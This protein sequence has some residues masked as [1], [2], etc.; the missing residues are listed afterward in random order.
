MNRSKKYMMVAALATLSCGA[1]AQGLNT[2]YFIDG[3]TFR[4]NLNPAYGNDQNYV[5]IPALG[6]IQVRTQGNFGLGDVLFDNPRYGIDSDKKKTTFMNPYIA[7]GEALK[8]FASGNNRINADV[9]IT[10]LSAGFKAWGGYNTISLDA[11]TN[12][13]L[14]LPYELFAFA[15]NTGNQSYD[16]GDIHA[17]AQSFVQLALGHSRQIDDR[18]RVGA[19][20]KLLFGVARADAEIKD[21][22]AD[23]SGPDKWTMT[24]QAMAN[25]SMKGFTYKEEQKEYKVDGQGTYRRVND[26]DVDGAGLGGFGMA[27]DFGATYKMDGERRAARP[28]LHRMEQ[29]HAGRQSPDEFRVQRLPRR[30]CQERGRHGQPEGQQLGVAGRPLCRPDCRLCQPLQR[31]RQ[32]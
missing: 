24:G 8:G 32:G 11:R 15:K 20:M 27:F 16:I 12:V 5:S 21:L 4:H 17:H 23:L 14:S 28:W 18:L 22:R 25:V 26:V 19:K 7:D 9:D 3:Y 30:G 10:L 29:Q 13:G 2:G 31:W 6:N 1:M